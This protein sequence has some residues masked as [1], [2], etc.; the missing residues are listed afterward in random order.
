MHVPFARPL[1]FVARSA[2]EGK[3]PFRALCAARPG[4]GWAHR[5]TMRG[6]HEAV[7]D[8]GGGPIWAPMR[9]AMRWPHDPWAG[10][11]GQ[12]TSFVMAVALFT[13]V[14]A[15]AKPI[16]EKLAAKRLPQIM[17]SLSLIV[18]FPGAVGDGHLHRRHGDRRHLEL[19]AATLIIWL[20]T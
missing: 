8:D 11:R 9:V 20:S 7:P 15:V 14:Q 17:G 16:L 6:G 1:P 18:V 2:C 5:A 3:A 10:F 4:I 12:L 13:V 19:A